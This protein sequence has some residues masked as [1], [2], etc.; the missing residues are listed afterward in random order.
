MTHL[1]A[2][3]LHS[4]KIEPESTGIVYLVGSGPGSV[5]Y[6]TVKAHRMLQQAEV[7][8]YDALVDAEALTLTPA[9]CICIDVGKRGGKP[10]TPQETINRILVEHCQ[11]GKQVVRLKSGDPF[12]F[13]R[14]MS[15][16][17]A[18]QSAGCLYELV[19]GLSS[20]LAAPLLANIP[21]TDPVLS[22]GFSVMSGHRADALN[23]DV[24]AQMDTLVVLMG[25]QQLGMIVA[26]LIDR[27]RSP[28]TPIAIIQWA[29][30]PQ[31]RIWTGTLESIGQKTSRQS[32]SPAVMVIGEVVGLMPYITPGIAPDAL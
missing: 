2:S 28:K 13:G 32:L 30:H 27:G 1:S 9:S 24:L 6:L 10:S 19:P 21:L 18:L 25:T 8:V 31:Q 12:V 16:I 14:C 17:E 4:P 29:S 15:E 22:Q 3:G 26:S 5:D 11:Q 20:A 7:V 23:W